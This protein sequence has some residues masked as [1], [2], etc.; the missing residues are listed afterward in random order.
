MLAI[1]SLAA[2]YVGHRAE[3]RPFCSNAGLGRR[4]AC[5]HDD[6][7]EQFHDHDAAPDDDPGN[8]ARTG[9]AGGTHGHVVEPD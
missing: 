1:T 2:A 9:S 4:E 8:S 6:H 3:P 5:D 7:R